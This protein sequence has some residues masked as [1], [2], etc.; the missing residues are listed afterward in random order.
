MKT[1]EAVD[2]TDDDHGPYHIVC[3]DCATE[4]L[5]SGEAEAEQRLSE[6]RSE[7]GH[8]VE[9]APLYDIEM[10]NE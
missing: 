4:F 9:F 7:T 1:S 5:T 3:H 8:N 2:A 10:E 6:H